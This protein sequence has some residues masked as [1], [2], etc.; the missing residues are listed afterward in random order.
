VELPTV[1]ILLPLALVALAAA[2]VLGTTGFGFGLFSIPFLMLIFDPHE[3]V[4]MSQLLSFVII[5]V[6][7]VRYDVREHIR[8]PLVL[9]LFVTSLVGIPI[10]AYLLG[11]IDGRLL[12]VAT[13]LLVIAASSAM[14]L[15][16]GVKRKNGPVALLLAGFTSG[17][18]ATSTSLSGTPI[19][20]L[21]STEEMTKDVFRSSLAA[22]LWIN[23]LVSL[24]L[25]QTT[26]LIPIRDLSLTAVAFPALMIGYLLGSHFFGRLSHSR[27]SQLVPIVVI[28]AGSIGLV[29]TIW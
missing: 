18:L 27:F 22:Y 24:A 1:V 21:V 15:R 23:T 7:L 16:A 17:L 29:T 9:P 19:A 12:R 6:M 2:I 20:M 28:I 11:A 8:L 5:T 13:S 26:G 14:L 3:A 10:G 4:I 25:L